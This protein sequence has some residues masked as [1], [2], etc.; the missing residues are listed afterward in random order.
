MIQRAFLAA[1]ASLS[2]ALAVAACAAPAIGD[3][4]DA[5]D[6]RPP[7]DGSCA[8]Q[9]VTAPV[10]TWIPP[11]ALHSNVCTPQDAAAIVSCFVPRAQ[12]VVR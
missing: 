12:M 4:H 8:P 10:V 5:A 11:H 3:S 2:V 7:I 9:S 6:A 1:V